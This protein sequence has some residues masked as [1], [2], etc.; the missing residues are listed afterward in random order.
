M[1]TEFITLKIHT[2][3]LFTLLNLHTNCAYT[4]HIYNVSFFTNFFFFYQTLP[5]FVSKIVCKKNL[6]SHSKIRFL[7]LVICSS[8]KLTLYLYT[9]KLYQY[10]TLWWVCVE[11][12]NYVLSKKFIYEERTNCKLKHTHTHT[13]ALHKVKLIRIPYFI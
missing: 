10:N 7:C 2:A 12:K 9:D 13:H 8:R 4:Y 11:K 5:V 1:C 6:I 3:M